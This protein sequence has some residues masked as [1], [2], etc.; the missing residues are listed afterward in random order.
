MNIYI[1]Q[2]FHSCLG[3]VIPISNQLLVNVYGQSDMWLSHMFVLSKC[4]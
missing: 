2:K 3:L 1:K 4:L